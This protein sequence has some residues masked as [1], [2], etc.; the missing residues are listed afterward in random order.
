MTQIWVA[1]GEHLTSGDAS[2][3][4]W[5]KILHTKLIIEMW[6]LPEKEKAL[7]TF[8]LWHCV[9]GTYNKVVRVRCV[10]DTVVAC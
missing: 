3:H 2:K 7:I 8:Q 1:S 5:Q 6:F 4:D 10:Y 9:V